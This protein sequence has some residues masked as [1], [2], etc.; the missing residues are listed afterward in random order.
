[1][2]A[3]AITHPL[4]HLYLPDQCFPGVLSLPWL[5][6][7]GPLCLGKSSWPLNF[8][9]KSPLPVG[10][11]RDP[12]ATL[13][14]PGCGKRVSLTVLVSGS[15]LRTERSRVHCLGPGS[16]SSVRAEAGPWRMG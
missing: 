11:R 2:K 15:K 14:Q 4:S 9:R 12:E 5:D 10:F 8:F 3:M 13:F 6:A 1:M 16:V 7:Q